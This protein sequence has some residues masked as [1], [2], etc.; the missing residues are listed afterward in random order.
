MYVVVGL[1]TGHSGCSVTNHSGRAVG[2]LGMRTGSDCLPGFGSEP[3]EFPKIRVP[4]S[5]V[6]IIRILL[7][8]VLY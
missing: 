8:R 1:Y 5:G 3:W 6:L 7:L 4:Y 2:K